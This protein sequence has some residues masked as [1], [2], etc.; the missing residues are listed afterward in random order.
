[1]LSIQNFCYKSLYCNVNV[2]CKVIDT[3]L[4]KK[5]DSIN[6]YFKSKSPSNQ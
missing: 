5:K 2:I 4:I 1:M 6:N 3:P